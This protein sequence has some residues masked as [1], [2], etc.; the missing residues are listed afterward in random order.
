MFRART[1][2]GSKHSRASRSSRSPSAASSRT[3][4]RPQAAAQTILGLPVGPPRCSRAAPAAHAAGD[5]AP[6]LRAGEGFVVA[7]QSARDVLMGSFRERTT[8]PL[9]S[10]V[11]AARVLFVRTWEGYTVEEVARG[12]GLT[13][14][15]QAAGGAQ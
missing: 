1:A 14:A 4:R 2:R 3:A 9:W 6:G 12:A 15:G 13:P 8:K 7:P 10:E 11:Q 5:P